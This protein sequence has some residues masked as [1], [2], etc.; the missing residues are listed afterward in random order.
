MR[1]LIS[2]EADGSAARGPHLQ[3]DST[4]HCSPSLPPALLPAPALA[5]AVM[6]LALGRPQQTLS[7]ASWWPHPLQH[8]A[9]AS[10]C[11]V[12]WAGPCSLGCGA[13]APC[14]HPG[15]A[16]ASLAAIALCTCA[17]RAPVSTLLR[18]WCP[19]P[20]L[21]PHWAHALHSILN[22]TCSSFR[23]CFRYFFARNFPRLGLL[24]CPQTRSFVKHGG[25]LAHSLGSWAPGGGAGVCPGLSCCTVVWRGTF[26]AQQH[27]AGMLV[28]LLPEPRPVYHGT[29]LH[30]LSCFP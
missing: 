20:A 3:R 25:L 7:W 8:P 12:L 15:A 1:K 27:R 6:T 18:L 11:R 13:P 24:S 9:H 19:L 26:E 21:I 17:H 22:G 28:R 10:I 14:S 29:H 2:P 4:V 16:P 23:T 30:D 5:A